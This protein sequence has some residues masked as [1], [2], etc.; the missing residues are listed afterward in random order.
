[1]LQTN[2]ETCGLPEARSMNLFV[3]Y[4]HGT[5]SYVSTPITYINDGPLVLILKKHTV[6]CF[7]HIRVKK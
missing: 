3:N 2:L 6:G 4:S 5:E 1:M 7:T